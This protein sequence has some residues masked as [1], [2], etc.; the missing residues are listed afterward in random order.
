MASQQV[1]SL[2]TFIAGLMTPLEAFYER[3]ATQA[4][5]IC[6]IQPYPDGSIEEISWRQVG[7]QVRKMA[8]YLQ[9]L[10][11]APG[12]NIAILSNN[13]AHWIMADLAI[14]MSGHTS[15]PLYPVLTA[16]SVEQILSHSGAKAIFAGKLPGF[17]Q[18]RPGIPH[19]VQILTFPLS[20]GEARRA[21]TDWDEV[22][23]T[24]TELTD[25]PARSLDELA[26]IIYTSGTTGVPKG[27]MHSF[28]TLALV[29]KQAGHIYDM[30]S[31]DRKLSYLPMAHVAE[32]VA[33]EINQ[34]YYGYKTYFSDSL[35]T[36]AEDLRRAR[37]TLCFAVPRIWTKFQQRVLE[38]IPQEELHRLL[39]N[40]EEAEQARALVLGGLGLDQTRVG[41]SG[42]APLPTALIEWFQMLGIEILEGYGMTENF[43]Y[44]HST[45]SGESRVGYVGTP[46]NY[47]QCKLG[48]S[49]EIMVK[50]PANMLGYYKEPQLTAEAFDPEGFLHTGDKGETDAHGRLKITGRIKEI[51]KTSKGKYVAPAPIENLL[52]RNTRLEQVCVTGAEQPAPIGLATLSESACEHLV[53]GGSV[54]EIISELESLLIETNSKLDKHEQLATLVI[55]R[56]AWSI[57]D[58]LVT[59]TLKIK[60]SEIDKSFGESFDRWSAAPERVIILTE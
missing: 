26:T 47:V 55:F 25:S 8:S 6:F 32:R 54:G 38:Q 56:R 51:F 28:Q 3:E 59:P 11:F 48:D 19:G 16:N 44:S 1:E 27:V 20:P 45:R 42:A 52:S 9:A 10:D 21:Y 36:F 39:S 30:S 58:N 12:S 29:G 13:C 4:D 14:W 23:A 22:V 49:G 60:R 46:S 40:P 17:V 53:N 24:S 57:E 50:S 5:E 41:V 34:L 33:I 15:V 31:A 2:E 43:A 7:E 35:A 18:M 37:P